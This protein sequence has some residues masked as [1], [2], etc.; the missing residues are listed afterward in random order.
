MCNPK[1]FLLKIK[2]PCT[3]LFQSC[4]MVISSIKSTQTIVDDETVPPSRKQLIIFLLCDAVVA[5][6]LHPNDSSSLT[7]ARQ[8]TSVATSMIFIRDP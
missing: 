4:V 2:S 6:P 8:R 5:R 1:L 7:R 3:S